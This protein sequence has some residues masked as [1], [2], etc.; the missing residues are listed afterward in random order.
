MGVPGRVGAQSSAIAGIRE[1]MAGK[2]PL[3]LKAAKL[4]SSLASKIKTK[5]INNSSIF[6][7]SLKNNNKALALALS[8]Q[9]EK[10]KLLEMETVYLR[11]EVETQFFENASYRH[12]QN[13]LLSLLKEVQERVFG[14]LTA[15]VQICSDGDNSSETVASTSNTSPG[16][17]ASAG[18]WLPRMPMRV[19]TSTTLGGRASLAGH[20]VETALPVS[21]RTLSQEAGPDQAIQCTNCLEERAETVQPG[22]HFSNGT[23]CTVE[24][25]AAGGLPIQLPLVKDQPGKVSGDTELKKV[26]QM[27]AEEAESIKPRVS[28]VKSDCVPV[29]E[30]AACRVG[31]ACSIESLPLAPAVELA[32]P[33]PPPPQLL[34][35]EEPPRQETTVFD[36]EMELTVSETAVEIV[37][38]ESTAKKASRKQN[39][40]KPRKKEAVGTLRHTKTSTTQDKEEKKKKKRKKLST[41]DSVEKPSTAL[42]CLVPEMHTDSNGP[43]PKVCD[44]QSSGFN[45]SHTP[46]HK[47]QDEF[48]QGLKL[49]TEARKTHFTSRTAKDARRTRKTSGNYNFEFS[50]NSALLD[51]LRRSNEPLETITSEKE[52]TRK[53]YV[54]SRVQNSQTD[55]S[56][57][58]NC[59]ELSRAEEYGDVFQD[60]PGSWLCNQT[61][62][63]GMKSF[64]A[65]E[66]PEP[67]EAQLTSVSPEADFADSRRTYVITKPFSLTGGQGS[68]CADNRKTYTVSN[69]G[70]SKIIRRTSKVSRCESSESVEK[71]RTY[72][73]SKDKPHVPS[74]S[75]SRRTKVDIPELTDNREHHGV[76]VCITPLAERDNGNAMATTKLSTC[77][78]DQGKQTSNLIAK[79]KSRHGKRKAPVAESPPTASECLQGAAAQRSAVLDSLKQLIV[80]EKPPWEILPASPSS[81]TLWDSL[82]LFCPPSPPTPQGAS[83]QKETFPQI[84]LKPEPVRRT[85]DGLPDARALKSVTNTS[86]SSSE[87]SGR[88]RRRVAAAVSYKEPPINCKMRREDTSDK[89]KKR[90]KPQ[91]VPEV[92]ATKGKEQGHLALC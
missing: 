50:L 55:I 12:K 38:V 68:E 23:V 19:P 73:V 45:L 15:A 57:A 27:C 40:A 66:K 90:K 7:I 72:V 31:E 28:L 77:E 62:G 3:P 59:A 71:R 52:G 42:P 79:V 9:K 47:P 88:K 84:T 21:E 87:E 2:K 35:S 81:G 8:A 69:D 53:T 48:E 24:P 44:P 34:L 61:L 83:V 60:T 26:S 46:A 25:E 10:C 82:P 92:Q 63:K 30:P 37:T 32:D 89:P 67:Q 16:D 6:K 80:N 91:K 74:S 5:N 51:D 39:D 4:N 18:M 56:L 20:T 75:S 36:A 85:T 70:G 41:D 76:S 29:R 49:S 43:A 17:A 58:E 54:V 64:D 86:H 1:I 11:K 22:Q 65:F 78:E 13:Q 14:T 33:P